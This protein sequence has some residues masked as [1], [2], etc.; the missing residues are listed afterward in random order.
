MNNI[1][2]N[3]F[4]LNNI[5]PNSSK[6]IDL[7]LY[8]FTTWTPLVQ[9]NKNYSKN[10]GSEQNIA[11][12]G[13]RYLDFQGNQSIEIEIQNSEISTI[14]FAGIIKEDGPIIGYS[15]HWSAYVQCWSY[16]TG[17]RLGSTP[18]DFSYVIPQNEYVLVLIDVDANNLEINLHLNGVLVETMPYNGIQQSMI[19][20]IGSNVTSLLDGQLDY[21]GVL[22]KRLTAQQIELQN[23]NPNAFY[24]SCV[25]PSGDLYN[26][27]L[28]ATDFGVNDGYVSDDRNVS[29]GSELITNGDFS[30]GTANW[31]RL[32]NSVVINGVLVTDGSTLETTIPSPSVGVIIGET[33]IVSYEIKE[34]TSGQG[35]R[36]VGGGIYPYRQTSI[37]VHTDIITATITTTNFELDTRDT[38]GKID[39]ISVKPIS[40]IYPI[41]NYSPTMRTNFTAQQSGLNRVFRDVNDLGFYDGLRSVP[42]GDGVS[43]GDTGWIPS[44]DEDWTLEGELSLSDIVVDEYSKYFGNDVIYA[45]RRPD[46]N[47]KMKIQVYDKATQP[48]GLAF[49]KHIIHICS[50]GRIFLDKVKIVVAGAI[51]EESLKPL[52]LCASSSSPA[53]NFSN[54]DITLFKI[55]KKLLTDEEIQAL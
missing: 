53:V 18:I 48:S 54:D 51:K 45:E 16:K 20:R 9:D 33:Y 12:Y 3:R 15:E 13:S 39:N 46:N 42:K 24:D 21:L 32:N 52:W 29:V 11:W 34:Y 19:N 2:D 23:S 7:S 43:Y 17:V 4:G 1:F 40:N 27:T 14:F 6:K 22:D 31:D 25:N 35:Y 8:K 47:Q 41:L 36:I 5:F 30:N 38:I 37:G 44:A 55:H 26:N 28:F 49:G 50:D 10:E